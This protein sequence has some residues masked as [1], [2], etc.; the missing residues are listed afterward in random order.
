[1][2][3]QN[4]K[5][6]AKN[7]LYL[8]IRMLIV[9]FVSLFTVRIVLRVLGA[10]DY[11]L[12]NVVGGVVT[13]LS[14]LTSTMVSSSQRFF[15]Y[16]LGQDS[17]QKLFQY[18]NVTFWCYV[19][20]AFFIFIVAETLGLWFVKTQ[21]TITP[22][23]FEAAIWVYQC[24]VLSFLVKIITIPYNSLII[25]REKMNIYAIVGLFEVIL[26]LGFVYL[27]IVIPFDKLKA[28]ALLMFLLTLSL[29][30]FYIIYCNRNY[31]ECK[32]RLFWNKH[33]FEEIVSYSSWSLF[34]AIAG[35]FRSQGI[36]ILLNIFFGPIVNA[37][38]AIAY[39]V[40]GAINQFVINFYKAVQPQ[41][42]KYYAASKQN[43]FLTLIYRSSR[44]CFFLIIILSL[45]IFIDT[46]FI[47]DLWLE[48]VP[49]HTIL[50]TR[51]VILTAIIDSIAYPLQTAISATGRIK[52]FQIVTGGLLIL[53][54]PLSYFLLAKGFPPETTMYVAFF[55]AFLSQISR[56]LFAKHLIGLSIGIYSKNVLFINVLVLIISMCV[57]F[58]LRIPT[59]QNIYVS[60]LNVFIT[61][62]VTSITVL[63]IGI[64]KSERHILFSTIAKNSKKL[65]K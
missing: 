18:F 37:A 28:Y 60:F 11:G 6:I 36:N 19:F 27:L 56:I 17:N 33:D 32:I 47:L 65:W 10:E 7:T 34:G 20:L 38:R 48:N 16:S 44:Y 21:L 45:P 39:Q 23:R 46:P 53:N 24:S 31:K 64:P 59:G 9:M 52:Y 26:K 12:N 57:S 1:M 42:T 22:S 13:M 51:L 62:L 35:V 3:S 58:A 29:D 2:S 8:Y 15:A 41:I 4:N 40:N 43:E 50:F 55:I 25:A 5:R 61:F 54:L 30:S 49:E 63:F 14:F